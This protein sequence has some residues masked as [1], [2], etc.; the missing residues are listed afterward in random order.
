MNSMQDILDINPIYVGYMS[1]GRTNLL[2]VIGRAC[3]TS[4]KAC[5]PLEAS[6][7]SQ[8]ACLRP[9]SSAGKAAAS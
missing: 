4:F 1:G 8:E 3:R 6:L 2:A 9:I 7:P 5:M